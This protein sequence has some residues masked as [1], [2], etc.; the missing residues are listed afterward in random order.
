LEGPTAD[1][2]YGAGWHYLKSLT[3][4]AAEAQDLTNILQSIIDRYYPDGKPTGNGNPDVCCLL[5][6]MQIKLL[7]EA[8]IVTGGVQPYDISIDTTGNVMMVSA[9]DYDGCTSTT[10]FILSS[11]IEEV[12]DGI[13]I[14]PNPASTEIYVDLT[15]SQDAIAHLRIVSLHGQV[16][17]QARNAGRITVSTLSEGVYI[18]QIELA[19][20]AQIN[21]RVLILR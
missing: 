13:K 15:E 2:D 3:Y 11:L 7:D 21:K 6:T 8:V 17:Q 9:V 12:R 14:Y 1:P 4:D 5:D 10:Q 19:G 16:L 18:L 20:G